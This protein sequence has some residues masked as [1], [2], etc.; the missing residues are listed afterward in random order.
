MRD[1]EYGGDTKTDRKK[2]KLDKREAAVA[3]RHPGCA[4]EMTGVHNRGEEDLSHLTVKRKTV[5]PPLRFKIQKRRRKEHF[6]RRGKTFLTLASAVEEIEVVT[7]R[8]S[9]RGS[10]RGR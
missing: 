6:E 8:I 5:S 1:E 2:N 7:T 4:K 9:R 10:H 3:F